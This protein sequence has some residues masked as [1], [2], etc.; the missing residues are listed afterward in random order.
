[1]NAQDPRLTRL[2]A[3]AAASE[4]ELKFALTDSMVAEFAERAS[5]GLTRPALRLANRY[6]DTPAGE[7]M[8]ARVSLRVRRAGDRFVQTVK[9]AGEG[10]FERFEWERPIAGE[11][12]ELDAL[13][14]SSHPAGALIRDGFGLL[15]PVFETNF[16]REL[17]LVQP[18]PGVRVEV[19]CDRGEI[20][21]GERSEPIAE[22][23]FERK[24]GP[25]AAFYH[26][27]LQW[28]RLHDA[29]LLLPSKNER[30][31][32]LAGWLTE[33][34][35]VKAVPVAPPASAPTCEAA[36]AILH[37]HLAAFLANAEPVLAGT[38]AEGPHQLRVALRRFRS[39]VRFFDLR[40][41]AGD[42]GARWQA[43][44]AAARTLAGAAG[45][46]RDADVFENGLL[47]QLTHSF[48]GDAALQVLRRAL[49][50]AREHERQLLRDA[51]RAPAATAFVLEALVA[52]ESLA[53]L[54]WPA[55]HFEAFASAR[56]AALARRARRRTARAA[57]EADWHEVRIAIKN[58]RYA[59]D[60]CRALDVTSL[61]VG[62]A[63]SRLAEWQGRLGLGQDLAVAR[64]VA[65][66]ALGYGAAPAG[67]G[68]RA[69]AL[70]DGYRAFAAR[71]AAPEK[72]RKP[73]RSF[74]DALLKDPPPPREP[75]SGDGA[76]DDGERG[77]GERGNGERGDGE[78]GDRGGPT[79]GAAGLSS[80]GAAGRV[81]GTQI[82]RRQ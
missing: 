63:I 64:A 76:G 51:I 28:A 44:D 7:L 10:P 37:G 79:G 55:P 19:A 2:D 45:F 3:V 24:E 61:P 39:A 13:P 14:P 6:F 12:P 43:V 54:P 62:D 58:L 17:R 38:D 56:L 32:R 59:L 16:E 71:S 8:N 65:S 20:R 5:A 41:A 21:A 31:L 53:A 75:A 23:E 81:R 9:A 48:P 52:I 60:G 15:M 22:V 29:R 40:R 46:V 78:R 69:A 30:G 49:L 36:R 50:Q 18:Q 72:L 35:P 33:P 66:R 26:Y 82:G 4:H 1:M 73:I 42:D 67:M 27:A 77:N 25:A 70:I 68:V 57:V 34:A 80:D 74:L 11:Q 47:A